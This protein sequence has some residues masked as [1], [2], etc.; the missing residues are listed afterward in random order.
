MAER[1]GR[2]VPRS[3]L[4]ECFFPRFATEIKVRGAWVSVEKPLLPGYLIGISSD[5][6]ALDR[7][8]LDLEGFARV[9]MQGDAYVPLAADE[10]AVVGGF[11]SPGA[12]VIPM[13]MAVK[14]GDVVT[15]TSGPLVGRQGLI[16]KVN[17]RKSLAYLEFDL[18]GRK[19]TARVGLGIV[20]APESA[21][22]RR[23]DLYLAESRKSA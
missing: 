16:K 3:V 1:I 11:T 5:P 13:S 12:R 10:R 23:A 19:V 22:A 8:L 21:A 6:E 2:V 18:C 9:L 15:V 4:E 20:T 14:Q 7:A 17:R